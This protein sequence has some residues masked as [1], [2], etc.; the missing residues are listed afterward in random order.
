MS[1]VPAWQ[2]LLL[3]PVAGGSVYAV[4]CLA[5]LA[6]F[7]QRRRRWRTAPSPRPP[8]TVLKPL[9]GL[10]K[11]LREN[12][13]STCR[14][15]WPRLQVVFSLQDPAD[16]A[17]ALAQAVQREVGEQTVD[18]A[19]VGDRREPNA[20]V[21]NLLGGLPRARHELLVISDSDMRLRPDYLQAIVAPLA[22]ETVGC[23]CTFYRAVGA[24][25]WWERLEL[26]TVN[27]DLLPNFLFAWVTG[28]ARFVLGGST[29]L[30][31]STLE[32]IGGL[33]S[34]GDY[35]L[36]DFEMGRRLLARG[37]RVVLVPYLIDT[38]IGL[39]SPRDWW[40]HQV[41]W[42]QNTCAANGWGQFGTVALKAVPF[43]LLFAAARLFDPLGVAVLGAALAWR[44]LT[45]GVFLAGIGD[46]VGLRSLWLLP[47]RDLV[48]LASWA[49]AFTRPVL[50]WR[51]AE[52]RLGADG[53]V[54]LRRP[55]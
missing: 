12:L 4:G 39:R 10:E 16:P 15:D 37:R 46:G 17:L 27:A 20:K 53:R 52:L 31:R 5:A 54:V 2:W 49:L 38:V 1:A 23:S 21:R 51:G 47:V 11:G 30:S 45:T 36:E 13:L 29:A 33:E 50:V 44:V 42:D 18:V 6:V 8:V 48:A 35:L 55:L 34:L 9:R 19:V 40:H 24:E 28:A 14:Q 26:L 25:R 3:V 7:R 32:A 22:D 43:A 41:Y